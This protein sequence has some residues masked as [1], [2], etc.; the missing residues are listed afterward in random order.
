[1]WWIRDS[2]YPYAQFP[3]YF[4]YEDSFVKNGLTPVID[5]ELLEEVLKKAA[6]AADH[7]IT[8]SLN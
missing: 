1:M 2:D 3:Y 7:K 8:Q 5:H 4:M 6:D